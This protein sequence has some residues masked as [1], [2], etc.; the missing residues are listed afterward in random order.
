VGIPLIAGREFD[1]RDRLG[2][3]PV[4][5][6]NQAAARMLYP[7]E[8]PVGKQLIV[9][10]SGPP[11]AEI[12]GI[13]ADHRF[14]GL[15]SEP[16]PFIFL[17]NSQR[18]SLIMG[19]VVRTAGDPLTMIKAV[20][21]ATHS[22]D[23][24]QGVLETTTMEQ[25]LSDSV[26]QPR[27][28][29]ILLGAF[30]VLALVLA[31][32]GIYGVLAYAV[33]QRMREMGVRM[34]LGAV[35]GRILREILTGGLR[36]AFLGLAIGLAAAFA[37]TRYLQTLLY[38]VKPTDPAV[39]AISIAALLLVAAAACSLPALRAARVDPIVVLREE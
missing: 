9:A 17:P 23:P 31:C 2:G 16:G 33:S 13:V 8:N 11:Q 5:V 3:P 4:A 35:P 7:D 26:A 28:Q 30:G 12:V 1:V 22:V 6:I 25:R 10:W 37:L 32:I 39:F 29:T 38:S 34:A 15:E 24:E 20:R 19:L 27:L 21:E 18:P 14:Q 36:L